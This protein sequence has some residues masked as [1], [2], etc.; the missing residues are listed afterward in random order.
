MISFLTVVYIFWGLFSHYLFRVKEFK[1]IWQ[2]LQE[3]TPSSVSCYHRYK[4]GRVVKMLCWASSP[5]WGSWWPP[6]ES[7]SSMMADIISER[8]FGDK[9]NQVSAQTGIELFFH[10]F[11]PVY[12]WSCSTIIYLMWL[13]IHT[14]SKQQLM[15]HYHSLS[16]SHAIVVSYFVCPLVK[17]QC[18]LTF[19][20]TISP[21]VLKL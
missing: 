13:H 5:L 4:Y 12:E 14:F 10:F 3:D 15:E 7:S 18:L 21:W 17:M 1:L 2:P 9:S 6:A 19:V 16:W 20:V 11:V 8:V